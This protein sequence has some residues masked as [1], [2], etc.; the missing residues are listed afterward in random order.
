MS[1]PQQYPPREATVQEALQWIS[2]GR[3]SSH[4][5]V[6]RYLDFLK[7]EGKELGAIVETFETEALAAAKLS[8][9]RREQGELLG[10]LDGTLRDHFPD[11]VSSYQPQA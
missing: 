10:P 7:T 11:Q 5:L 6:S 2:E 1:S 4:D 8:D 3:C 9:K